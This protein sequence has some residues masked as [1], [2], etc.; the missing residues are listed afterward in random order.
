MANSLSAFVPQLWANESI[1]ILQENMV[2]A[3]LVYRDFEEYIAK[4]GDVVNTRKP[5]EFTAIRKLPTDDVTDQDATATNVPVPLNQGVHV[6]FVIKD[7]E[8]SKSFKNLVEE[9]LK[10]AMLAQ[11]RFID[12][13]V[14]GQYPQFLGTT[15]GGLAQMSS[16]TAKGFMLDL[17]KVMT[18]NKAY[19][20]G[21]NLVWTPSSNAEA[22]KTDLFVAAYANADN[23]DAMKNAT[24]GRRLGFDNYECQNASSVAVGNTSVT[25]A[26]NGGNLTKGS[27]SLTVNGFSAAITNGAWC[28]IAGD[29]TPQQIVSTT[30]GATPTGLVITPGLR[31]TISNSAVVK[32]YT[33]GAV[34]QSVSPTGYAAGWAKNI[35]VDGFTVAPQLGQLVNFGP[36]LATYTIVKGVSSPSTTLITLDRPLD[37]AIAD[38]DAVCIGPPGDYNFAFH[39]NAIALVVRPLILPRPGV[40]AI[41]AVVNDGG[42]SMRVVITYDGKAQGH[43]VTFDML[44]GIA[45]LDTGL[46]AVML[47]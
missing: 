3:N 6:T 45:I 21:R 11:A 42:L 40:G 30:G 4:Y 24:M 14:L 10:P 27:T 2:A 25:G 33:P 5:S 16:S 39:R 26:I 12:Q 29:D 8:E 15:A 46:G 41:G 9:Y 35:A 19:E 28:T 31:K 37:A 18:Q 23:G 47:G 38:N 34:N 32:V 22:M 7:G 1:A 44:C 20:D 17:K 36:G 13:I 43:R